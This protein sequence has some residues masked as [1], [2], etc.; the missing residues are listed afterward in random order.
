MAALLVIV[1]AVGATLAAWTLRNQLKQVEASEARALAEYNKGQEKLFQAHYD[2]ARAQR[3]S[4]REG[5]RFQSIAA[6]EEAVRIGRE[7][8]LPPE[9]FE[10]L[11]DEAIAAMALPDLK[12]TGRLITRPPG[13]LH[14][15]L[16]PPMTRYAVTFKDGSIRVDSFADGHEIFRFRGTAGHESHLPHFS[17]DGRYLAITQHPGS[18][19]NVWDVERRAVALEDPGPVSSGH[20]ARFSPD[21]RQFALAHDDGDLLT[22]DL[23]T[24]Q[25][26]RRWHGPSP[27]PDLAFRPDGARIAVL[28]KEKAPTCQILQADTGGLVKSIPLPAVGEWVAWSPDG[29]ALATPCQD[30][31]IYLWDAATGVRTATLEGHTN[32]G[33]VAAF[34]PAGALLASNDWDGWLRLWDPVL[35]RPWFSVTHNTHRLAFSRDGS[36]C[37]S[38]MEELITYQVDPARE[39][40]TLAPVPDR[41]VEHL[42]VAIRPD[43]RVAALG[44]S[45]GVAFFDL[46]NGSRLAFLPIRHVRILFDASGDL[47]TS[48]AAGAWRWPVRLESDQGLRIGPPRRLR[49]PPG[50]EDFATDRTG[51]I[52]ALAD[53]GRAFVQTPERILTLSPLDDVRGIAVSPDGAWVVTGSHGKNGFQVWRSS[54]GARVADRNIEGLVRVAFSPDGKRLMTKNP[55]CRLWEVGTWRE[56]RR[57]DG[58]GLCFSADGRLLAIQDANKVIRLVETDSARTIA[59]LENPDLCKVF[60]ASFSP[61]GS[62]LA[63]STNDGPAVH[64][65]DLRRIRRRLARMGLDWDA[66][67]YA[68]TDPA[69]ETSQA[70]SSIVVDLGPF[71]PELRSLLEQAVQLERSGD[72]GGAIDRL[73]RAVRVSPEYALAYNNLAWLLV[74][75]PKPHRKL[76]EALRHARRAVELEPGEQTSLNTLGVTLYRVGRFAEAIETLERSLAAGKGQYAA[77]DLFFLAMA[78]HRLDHGDQARA[79]LDQARSWMEAHRKTL[80]PGHLKELTDFR[81]EAEAVLAGASAELPDDVFAEPRG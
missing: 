33:L 38:R 24:G 47:L 76:D 81:A 63:I 42:D 7:L 40:R 29:T 17:P 44:T 10:L 66:P 16:D 36:L 55:P 58:L 49:L 80:S 19:L 5:Q 78:H 52:V 77:F 46:A 64:I 25:I 71:K 73:R 6:L 45:R 21:S 30:R 20:S 59:R 35:G 72:V 54:D 4:R 57:I 48:G 15:A 18:A 41:P 1:L 14:Y 39:Y 13:L 60:F 34:H 37:V 8:H 3:F 11:R 74:T 51:G 65:W 2:R 26:V 61:D 27:A 62:R 56:A 68:E 75:A 12:P 32:G 53:H 70:F 23:S 9:K 31:K 22:Y 69:A 28:Y 50:R 67:P 43:G 79:R